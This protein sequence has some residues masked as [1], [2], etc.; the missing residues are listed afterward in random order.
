MNKTEEFELH[1]AIEFISKIRESSTKILFA[2][3]ISNYINWNHIETG[4]TNGR[5]SLVLQRRYFSGYS[6]MPQSSADL[7]L[8]V[9]IDVHCMVTYI[10]SN[11]ITAKPYDT[12]WSITLEV[13]AFSCIYLTSNYLNISC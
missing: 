1:I 4:A 11:E 12:I 10:N 7:L 5:Q 6:E 9:A 13:Y 2:Y 3:T 8:C